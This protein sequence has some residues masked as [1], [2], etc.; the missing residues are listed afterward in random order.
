MDNI[1]LQYLANGMSWGVTALISA[2]ACVLWHKLRRLEDESSRHK[3]ELAKFK[4]HVA[5]NYCQ[6]KEIV[7][8]EQRINEQLNNLGQRFEQGFTMIYQQLLKRKE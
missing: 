7:G 6:K 8:L 2:F 4:I 1:F 3:D 5:E